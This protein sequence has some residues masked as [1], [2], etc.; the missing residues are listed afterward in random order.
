[1]AKYKLAFDMTEE[2]IQSRSSAASRIE[3]DSKLSA[4]DD[5]LK[6]MILH[7]KDIK[8]K[9]VSLMACKTDN[10]HYSKQMVNS[11]CKYE[12]R[13]F[14]YISDRPEMTVKALNRMIIGG[15]QNELMKDFTRTSELL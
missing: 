7:Y 9:V 6:K 5:F 2:N 11:L 10:L 15:Q 8:S 1:M 14:A 13:N 3:A 4:F 12:E